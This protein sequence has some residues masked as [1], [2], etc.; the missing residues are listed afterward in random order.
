MKKNLTAI[1]LIIFVLC[2]SL[3]AA[4]GT[5][6]VTAENV[7]STSAPSENYYSLINL[8]E[9][10]SSS[11][12]CG[13][14]F[15]GYYFGVTAESKIPVRISVYDSSLDFDI[16]ADPSSLNAAAAAKQTEIKR[17][18]EEV[19]RFI[20]N[21]DGLANTQYTTSDV[22]RFNAASY[23]A[24]LEISAETYSM[25]K[26]AE[27][28]FVDTDGAFDPAVYRLVDLWGFSSR[29]YGYN[30]DLPYDRQWVKN[31][32]GTWGYP[33]PQQKYVEA[34]SR[35]SDFSKVDLSEK[36]SKYYVYKN[37]PPVTVDGEEYQQW[38]DLG[39]IAK[40]Y[41]ADWLDSA[42]AE[43][44]YIHN[45][46]SLGGSSIT[47]GTQGDGSGYSL[48][49]TDP[50]SIFG[51]YG[52]VNAADTKLSTS[53]QYIRTY[54][55]DGAAYSHIIDGKTG[56][57]AATGIKTV[58][59][60]G[61]SAAEDDCLTTALTVMG[62]DSVM[63]FLNTYAEEKGLKVSIV[64]ETVDGGKQIISNMEK[65]DY[66]EGSLSEEY[67]WAVQR[68]D[69]GKLIYIAEAMGKL[70]GSGYTPWL[71]ALGAAVLIAAV[72]LIV[73]RFTRGKK[74][75][76]LSK[77]ENVKKDKL[78]KIADIGVY[79]LVL[80]LILVLFGIFVF[81]ETSSVKTI[82]VADI[83]TREKLFV[84]NVE[85]RE[86]EVNQAAGWTVEVTESGGSITVRLSKDFNGETRFN[87]VTV[88]VGTTT[89][90]SMTNSLCGRLQECVRNFPPLNKSGGAI[91][92]SPNGLK[93]LTDDSEY[94]Q[95]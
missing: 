8:T 56:R 81:D 88:A 12:I 55:I 78:F 1:L 27:K 3:S 41:V 51:Y 39:G 24:E 30:G 32:D 89:S 94:I 77:V 84:Y 40:G 60:I 64:Y 63:E 57:P 13:V 91:V 67:G 29:T 38:I 43:Q 42:L 72:A 6:S 85:R 28:M 25:L 34:F 66:I 79:A 61:G 20:D 76:P 16:N 74:K 75:N 5:V 70:T 93:I 15:S 73:Y 37:C 35:L 17:F 10:G 62:K 80:L 46:V 47:L 44:G 11:Q 50:Y 2:V 9:S 58:T 65:T 48:S 26:T 22:Y 31:A 53:G 68:N 59:V 36:D 82:T 86:Y 19:H 33:L 92:C 54:T 49:L 7:L 90:V 23:G 69:E 95:I 4:E 83:A 71:I 87:E 21:I 18:F 14:A 52:A 45:F